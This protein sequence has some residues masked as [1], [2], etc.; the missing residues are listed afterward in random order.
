[1]KRRRIVPRMNDELEQGISEEEPDNEQEKSPRQIAKERRAEVRHILLGNFAFDDKGRLG[2]GTGSWVT[3][4]GLGDGAG[5]TIAFGVKEKRFSYSSA[6]KNAKQTVFKV[7]KAMEKTGR[8][9]VLESAPD[10][11]V[12]YVKSYVFRPVVLLFEKSPE[13]EDYKLHA[14][15]G[16]S[17]IAF[18]AVLRAVARLA[19]NL[20]DDIKRI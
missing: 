6:L 9:I 20:P 19:K 17:P 18:V 15:C 13:G 3:P 11:A 16:R 1:M 5:Q 12:C 14:Y 10:A 4:Y 2:A 7:G 8:A